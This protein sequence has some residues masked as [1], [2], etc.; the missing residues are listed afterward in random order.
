MLSQN[1][2][3]FRDAPPKAERVETKIKFSPEAIRF[4]MNG[5]LMMVD[6]VVN[7]RSG[8]FIFDT[9]ASDLVLQTSEKSATNLEANC[10]NATVPMGHLRVKSFQMGNFRKKH[11]DGYSLDLTTLSKKADGLIGFE[12]MADQAFFVRFS[13]RKIEMLSKKEARKLVKNSP[14]VVSIPFRKDRHLPVFILKVN[15]K[16][17]RV[18]LDTGA[19]K[20]ILDKRFLKKWTPS[21][22]GSELLQ[23][24]DGI[25]MKATKGRLNDLQ[26]KKYQ[27]QSMD[28][29]FHDLSEFNDGF[30][31]FRIDG[32]VGLPFFQ[33]KDFMIDYRNHKIHIWQ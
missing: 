22:M 11:F 14:N 33:G 12:V 6:V 32:L 3:A 20:N 8:S 21:Q 16:K 2:L 15:G 18:A 13:E 10:L 5:G 9:G 1:E 27:P 29:L 25:T 19:E 24:L 31:E 26:A 7:E 28:F 30:F 4:K 17:L 23:G